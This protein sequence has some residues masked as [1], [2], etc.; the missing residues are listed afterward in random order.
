MLA[1]STGAFAQAEF[2]AIDYLPQTLTYSEGLAVSGNGQVAL[3]SNLTVGGT[4][5]MTG[6]FRWTAENGVAPAFELIGSSSAA[7]GA[8][9]DGSVVTGWADYGAFS[10]LGVQAFVHWPGGGSILIGDFPSNPTGAPASYG[11]G[12]SADGSLVAGYGRSEHG[13]EGFVYR[14]ATGEFVGVGAFSKANFASWVYGISGNGQVAVGASRVNAQELQAF[15]WTEA[16]GMQGLGWLASPV[17]LTRYGIAQAA[18]ANGSVI[19]GQCRSV[20]S[21]N[22]VEAF[23]WTAENGLQGLGD[24][25]GGSFQS[26]AYAVSSN[27]AVIAGMATIEGPSGPFG[28]GSKP[29]AFLWDAQHGMRDL[30]DLLG[31]AGAPVGGWDLR[32]VRGLSADGLTMVGTGVNPLGQ[33]QAWIATLPHPECYP[34]CDGST[35]APILNIN[36][37]ICF[38]AR[39]AGGD[40]YAN[41]DGSTAEPVLNINDFICFQSRFASGCR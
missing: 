9:A 35:S 26:I 34:N 11:R 38:Q 36:D 17:G 32:D 22:G 15:R 10:P 24:L 12:V 7:A 6:A 5:G 39:F 25:A 20:N 31:A 21:G 8:S 18:S 23:R 3:G 41:C 37:F 4:G 2:R 1:G 40:P 16:G 30:Q 14:V 27:G 33:T 28:G 29:R 19:V 13:T